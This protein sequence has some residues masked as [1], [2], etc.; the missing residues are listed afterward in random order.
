MQH[1]YHRPEVPLFLN[2][3]TPALQ[4]ALRLLPDRDGPVVLLKPFGKVVYWRQFDGRMVAP[5][6]LVYAE[7]LVSGDP[8]AREAAEELRREFLQ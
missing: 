1:L 4:R 8:R 5:P 3:E 6:W 2:L 7:L